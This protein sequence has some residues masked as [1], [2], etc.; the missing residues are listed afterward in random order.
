MQTSILPLT[1]SLLREPEALVE[2][3][4]DPDT[5]ARLAPRLLAVTCGSAALFGAVA[6]SYRG[7]A[8][9]LFAAAKMPLL[10]LIP[11]VVGLPAVRALYEAF[12]ADV[13]WPRLAG[14]GLVAT[15]RA[16]VL[17]AALGPA[18]WLVYSVDPGY[19]PAVGLMALLLA[20]TGLPA[21]GTVAKATPGGRSRWIPAVASLALLGAITAQTGWLLRPFVARPTAEVTLVRP[22]EGDVFGSL[23]R[24]PLASFDVYLDYAPERR[25]LLGEGL[26]RG[27]HEEER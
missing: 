7:G 11:L 4:A 16:A 17:A 5:L 14:A 3:C 21:L 10:F 12:E 6:G 25:G 19:H 20:V 2:R 23:I 9:V 26:R 27:G 1:A 24:L 13:R 18:L 15:A 8:Q 22:I